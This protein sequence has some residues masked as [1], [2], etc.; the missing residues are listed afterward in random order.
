MKNNKK[1]QFCVTYGILLVAYPVY[2]HHEFIWKFMEKIGAL[3]TGLALFAAMYQGYVAWKAANLTREANSQNL[4]QQKFNLVLEQHNDS[5]SRVRDWLKSNNYSDSLDKKFPTEL[6]VGEIR[7]HEQ[8]SPY[9]RILYHTL[10]TIKEELP[11]IDK[12]DHVGEIKNQKRYTSLVRS[13]IPNDILFLVACNAS[14]INDKIFKI[15]DSKSYSYYNAML[16]DFDFFEHLKI[17]IDKKII[18]QESLKEVV[19]STYESCR[20]FYLGRETIDNV[21]KKESFHIVK[22]KELLSNPNFFICLAYNL[23]NKAIDTTSFQKG[24]LSVNEMLTFYMREHIEK[25]NEEELNSYISIETNGYYK[26]MVAEIIHRKNVIYNDVSHWNSSS[27]SGL[28]NAEK[29]I[30]FLNSTMRCDNPMKELLIFRDSFHSTLISLILNTSCDLKNRELY[31]YSVRRSHRE[32]IRE[33]SPLIDALITF[34]NE[35]D[36]STLP[37]T[38]LKNKK[39]ELLKIVMNLS[40]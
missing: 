19:Y 26:K 27:T 23:K 33:I 17:G 29:V 37:S 35:L 2:K 25:L 20:L 14:V 3:A 5:L 8:L 28:Y 4:F 13:F 11:I 22:L 31:E 40:N 1:W 10:K 7:G 36:Y 18:L 21:N 34:R 12:T 32:I 15:S 30:D 39:E 9:M 24:M 38:V 16:Q 6:L